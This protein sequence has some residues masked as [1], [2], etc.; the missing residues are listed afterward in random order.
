MWMCSFCRFPVAK[1]HNFGQI[2]TFGGGLPYQPPFTDECQIW[3]AVADQTHCLHLHANFIWMC[4][5]CRLPVAKNR[6]FGHI[7][8]FLG[9]QCRP[10]FTDEG[11]IWCAIA[12]SRCTL[13]CQILSRPVYS[14]ALCWRK[15]PIFAVFWTSAFSGV[16]N[17]QQSDK[18][19]HGAQLQT[20]PY[21]TVS[22]LFL[23]SNAVMPYAFCSK[24]LTLSSSAKILEI[25]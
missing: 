17:W 19:G 4:S 9:L 8:T 24:F 12:H 6:N 25:G 2:L 16:A 18:V 3:C 5:L 15:T 13:T 7:L 20:F 14:V 22:K 21:P 10:P 11:Q 23:Y 1:D